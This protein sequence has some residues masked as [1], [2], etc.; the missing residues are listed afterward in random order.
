M[1][2]HQ[3]CNIYNILLMFLILRAQS[4]NFFL[5]VKCNSLSSALAWSCSGPGAQVTTGA[6]WVTLGDARIPGMYTIVAPR[7]AEEQ[8]QGT[9]LLH[10]QYQG[11]TEVTVSNGSI[12]GKPHNGSMYGLYGIP[13]APQHHPDQRRW[14]TSFCWRTSPHAFVLAAP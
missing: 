7:Y 12:P 2:K 4:I 14:D 8:Y 13:L 6:D 10:Q 11:S 1:M 3:I 5:P 9:L